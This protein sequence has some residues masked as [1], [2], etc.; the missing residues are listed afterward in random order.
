LEHFKKP[1]G[2]LEFHQNKCYSG[3]IPNTKR[4][5]AKAADQWAHGVACRPTFVSVWPEA[6]WTRVYTTRGRLWQWRKSMEAELIGWP[7]ANR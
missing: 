6:S 2:N 7:A 1:Q 4:Q 3:D 5:C